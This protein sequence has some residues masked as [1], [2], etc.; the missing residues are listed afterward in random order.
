MN[1]SYFLKFLL[2]MSS[3]GPINL[4]KLSR[5]KKTT[6]QSDEAKTLAALGALRSKA[7]SPK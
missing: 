7:N 3:K 5:S 1:F 6:E 2:R 4:L